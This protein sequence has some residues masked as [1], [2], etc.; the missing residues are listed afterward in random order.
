M[1][2]TTEPVIQT[3]HKPNSKLMNTVKGVVCRSLVFGGPPIRYRHSFGTSSINFPWKLGSKWFE[4]FNKTVSNT[5]GQKGK[6]INKIKT[7]PARFQDIILKVDFL[8]RIGFSIFFQIQPTGQAD[9]YF[10]NKCQI[11]CD[12]ITKEPQSLEF[13]QAL[14]HN[15]MEENIKSFDF[16]EIALSDLL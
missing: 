13:L 15:S 2:N 10:Q 9:Y 1:V 3:N 7:F 4:E 6:T 11:T 14:A 8:G 16:K 12:T 5:T